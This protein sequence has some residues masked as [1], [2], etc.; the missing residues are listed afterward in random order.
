MFFPTKRHAACY[1]TT[2]DKFLKLQ[3]LYMIV[4]EMMGMGTVPFHFLLHAQTY[5]TFAASHLFTSSLKFWEGVQNA[6]VIL[7]LNFLYICNTRRNGR[8]SRLGKYS[9][10]FKNY[11]LKCWGRP[12]LLN[13]IEVHK[14]S[15]LLKLLPR[16]MEL[17]YIPWSF[18]LLRLLCISINLPHVHV[19]N[20]VVTSR[21]V[22]PVA[23]WNC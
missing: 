17:W 22:P 5:N 6:G 4:W 18:F 16:K 1:M 7:T 21:L 19:W 15:L 13:S 14:L 8:T 11:L 9:W 3:I 23:T 12:S 10:L 2:F 20:S